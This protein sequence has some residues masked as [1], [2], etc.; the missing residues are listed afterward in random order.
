M[1]VDICL[2]KLAKHKMWYW[3][4]FAII[5]SIPIPINNG[6]QLLDWWIGGLVDSMFRLQN[7]E[8]LSGYSQTLSMPSKCHNWCNEV[9]R[10]VEHTFPCQ[11]LL[12]MREKILWPVSQWIPN[13]NLFPMVQWNGW[14]W[15]QYQEV[16]AIYDLFPTSIWIQIVHENSHFIGKK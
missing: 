9:K 13:G 16:S 15:R 8:S 14:E 1:I 12:L 6:Q 4:Q 10:D 3:R 2:C 5:Y 7:M 11:D